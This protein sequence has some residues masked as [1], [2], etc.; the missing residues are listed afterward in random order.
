VDPF[1]E[2]A[3]GRR[4]TVITPE[5]ENICLADIAYS[6]AMQC[7]YTG[8][9]GR[10]Y[11]VAEHSVHVSSVLQDRG[12]GWRVSLLGLLH[13]AAEAFVGDM[14]APIKWH[15]DGFR[16]V[17]GRFMQAIYSSLCVPP[18]SKDEHAIVKQAD[19]DLLSVEAS[20]LMPSKGHGWENLTDPDD[21]PAIQC[22]TPKQARTEFEMRFGFLT[23][24]VHGE[25][26]V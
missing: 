23:N 4:V 21:A 20:L 14:A 3:S 19:V 11:S 7:R 5:P 18:A 25:R 1:I 15:L 17:E 2:T 9:C 22:W 6:L 8:H 12:H 10:F 24:H 16:E 26:L 13:D